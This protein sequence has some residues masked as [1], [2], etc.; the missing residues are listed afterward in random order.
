[1]Y[2]VLFKNNTNVRPLSL[3]WCITLYRFLIKSDPVSHCV[4]EDDGSPLIAGLMAVIILMNQ[5]EQD[6]Y[7]LTKMLTKYSSYKISMSFNLTNIQNP[8]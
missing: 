4:P 3:S 8:A 7:L 1:M 6:N 2:V 5:I